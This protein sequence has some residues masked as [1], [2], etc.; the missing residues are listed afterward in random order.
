MVLIGV[1]SPSHLM[2]M[3]KNETDAVTRGVSVFGEMHPPERTEAFRAATNPSA[4]GGRMQSLAAEFVFGH[5]WSDDRLDRRSRSLV[6]MG[7]LIAQGAGEEF[8]NHVRVALANGL[9]PQEIE[10]TI[11][12]AAAYAG[13][14]AALAAMKVAIRIFAEGVPD[15]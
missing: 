15:R 10:E 12:Q 7:V 9:S 14:P 5:I 13:F 3:S 11:T 1:Q 8:G 2:H 6:T 4:P